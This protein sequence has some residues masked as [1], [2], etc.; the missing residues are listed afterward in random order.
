MQGARETQYPAS[1]LLQ[2]PTFTKSGSCQSCISLFESHASNKLISFHKASALVTALCSNK[3]SSKSS[4]KKLG[5]WFWFWFLL[6]C[7]FVLAHSSDIQSI[8][9]GNSRSWKHLVPSFLLKTVRDEGC[10]SALLHL[11]I[12]SRTPTRGTVLPTSRISFSP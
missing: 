10:H 7:P 12:L 2:Q 11:C 9:V 1:I 4:F 5:F 3:S 8:L 6:L